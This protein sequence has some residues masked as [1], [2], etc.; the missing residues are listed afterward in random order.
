MVGD[1]F[2]TEL[3]LVHG[4]EA[5]VILRSLEGDSAD[6]WPTSPPLQEVIPQSNEQGDY[7]AGIGRAGKSTWSVIVAP[8]ADDGP[9]GFE[10]DFACRIKSEPEWLGSTYQLVA[11]NAQLRGPKVRIE[12]GDLA[13]TCEPDTSS[14][15]EMNQTQIII[16]PHSQDDALPRT[17]RWK[18]RFLI[19][20][21]S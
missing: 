18:Y 13:V 10:L 20:D 3:E 19:G 14:V 9:A 6:I 8:L 17:E 5:T 4:E 12:L 7:Q 21:S 11:S 2:A 15:V 1:R 16:K